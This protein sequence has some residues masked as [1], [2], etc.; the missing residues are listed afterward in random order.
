[1]RKG[2]F[3]LSCYALC[4]GCIVTFSSCDYRLKYNHYISDFVD[5]DTCILTTT[6]SDLQSQEASSL[7]LKKESPGIFALIL[8]DSTTRFTDF[9][10]GIEKNRIFLAK[11]GDVKCPISRGRTTPRNVVGQ[12]NT[13]EEISITCDHDFNEHF[14]AGDELNRIFIFQFL[15]N[16]SFIKSGYNWDFY[17][18]RSLARAHIPE[19]IAR[20][21][22]SYPDWDFYATENPFQSLIGQEVT[23]SVRVKFKEGKSLS[24]SNAIKIPPFP[25][26]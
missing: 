13:P 16:L 19:E 24:T 18:K 2:H 14:K 4:L 21:L 7:G 6:H 3:L 11:I 10:D 26:S 8:R 25:A 22:A 9:D 12:I 17:Q 23:F 1:M 20:A 15:D 5:A